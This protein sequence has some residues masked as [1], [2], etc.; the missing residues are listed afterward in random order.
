[1]EN[2]VY[3]KSLSNSHHKK[4]RTRAKKL[5]LYLLGEEDSNP[6]VRV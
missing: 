3:I 6:E 2:P 4:I 1:M 5:K